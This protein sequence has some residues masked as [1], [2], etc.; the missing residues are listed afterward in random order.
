MFDLEEI[1][2]PG[3]N[4][5]PDAVAMLRAPL[6]GPQNQQ[7]ESPLQDVEFLG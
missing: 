4:R 3:S 6:Q 7:I 1:V 5:P 2:G